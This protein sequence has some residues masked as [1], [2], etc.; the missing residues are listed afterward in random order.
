MYQDS[1]AWYENEKECGNAILDYCKSHNIPR[2]AIF[3]TTKLKHNNGRDSV[4]KAIQKSLDEC[5]LGYIDMYLIHGPLGDFDPVTR[6]R[7]KGPEA[8]KQS[9]QA[10]CEVHNGGMGPLKSIGISNFGVGHMQEIV[11]AN[12]TLPT[13]NQVSHHI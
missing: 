5:G 3:F 2:S 9:W 8:R 10:I 4:K 13:V 7:L 12:M 1:A 6:A 11:D